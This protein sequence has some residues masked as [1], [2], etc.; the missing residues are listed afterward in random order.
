M[1]EFK[2]P[3]EAAKE[4]AALTDREEQLIKDCEAWLERYLIGPCSKTTSKE[5]LDRIWAQVSLANC[6]KENQFRDLPGTLS[7]ERAFI[8][9]ALRQRLG[10]YN[11]IQ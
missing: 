4:I 5:E 10:V 7:V 1:S 3:E 11:Q 9:D 2:L 8:Y 6:D